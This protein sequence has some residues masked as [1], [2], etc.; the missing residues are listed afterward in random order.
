M[1]AFAFARQCISVWRMARAL[2]FIVCLTF[3]Q[4]AHAQSVAGIAIGSPMKAV[5]QLGGALS[6]SLISPP[7][8]I[9]GFFLASGSQLEVTVDTER[10]A[11]LWLHLGWAGNPE[12]ASTDFGGFVFGR[13]T[14]TA[15][16]RTCGSN[17][18]CYV[19]GLSPA[20]MNEDKLMFLNCYDVIAQEPLV[21]GFVTELSPEFIEAWRAGLSDLADLADHALLS[22]IILARRSYLE[23][24]WGQD[25]MSDDPCPPIVWAQW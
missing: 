2:V 24:I 9:R 5:W 11:V 15:I 25:R 19:E 6:D 10:D 8:A 21:V 3:C 13:T 22:W 7:L 18:F 1:T 14:L 17:G 16:R 4:E 12:D 20:F 23:V